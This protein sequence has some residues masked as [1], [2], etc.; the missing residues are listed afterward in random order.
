MR[1]GIH[2]STA[3]SL[4][5]A[6]LKAAELGANTFQIFSASPRMW[7]ARMPDKAAVRLLRAARERCDLHPLA[8]HANYLVNLAAHDP[9]VRA[10]SIAAFREELQRAVLMDADYLVLHP[11]SYRGRSVEEAIEAFA[12]ALRDSAMD[13]RH[14][15]LTVLLENTAGSGCAIGSRLEEL[16]EIRDR[17]RALTGLPIGY[18]LDTC[19]L[20][21]AGFDIA[22]A[23]G[24]RSTVQEVEACLGWNDVHLIHA[25]DSKTP[26][27]S[28]VDRHENIGEGHIG[29]TGFRRIL[30]HPKLRGKPFI[31]ETPVRDPGDDRRNLD[32]LKRLSPWA[33]NML[34]APDT[35]A[36]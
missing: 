5:K 30:R 28:R 25:N 3:G 16:R 14:A 18:C 10:K 8:I 4:E 13:F 26:L 20:L 22:T 17:T 12:V 9:I 11:G 19:H 21:A 1:L 33:R 31:L 15:G 2:T 6:A 35:G 34:V 32:T 29:A 7:R 36:S 24:L 27:G 23:P